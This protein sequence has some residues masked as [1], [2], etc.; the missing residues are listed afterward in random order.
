MHRLYPLQTLLCMVNFNFALHSMFH[1]IVNPREVERA[2]NHHLSFVPPL[3]GPACGKLGGSSLPVVPLCVP[4]T[5]GPLRQ[6]AGQFAAFYLGRS[7]SSRP[8]TR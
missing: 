5:A 4:A 8:E 6:F 3:V 1:P 2:R 7:R